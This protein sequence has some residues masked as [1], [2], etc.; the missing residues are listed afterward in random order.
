M[1]KTATGSSV[2]TSESNPAS[3]DPM[4][5]DVMRESATMLSGA[6]IALKRLASDE[7]EA[8]RWFHIDVAL[9]AE[10]RAIDSRDEELVR[11]KT[12]EFA[13]RYRALPARW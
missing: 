9:S 3:Y 1:A 5:Y 8:A 6:Y 7:A 10:V 11:A 4:V 13:E 2:P 12:A